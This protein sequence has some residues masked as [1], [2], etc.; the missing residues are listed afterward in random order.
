[1]LGALA[2]LVRAWNVNLEPST[3]ESRLFAVA[4]APQNSSEQLFS[5]ISA[6][7]TLC[8][9]TLSDSPISSLAPEELVECRMSAG[10]ARRAYLY[11]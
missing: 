5:G 3:Y 7:G 1:V 9:A 11:G 8:G 2:S 4:V 10:A 6:L